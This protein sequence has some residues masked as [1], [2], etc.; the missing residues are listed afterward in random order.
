LLQWG[1]R[2]DHNF[3]TAHFANTSHT[4][5]NFASNMPTAVPESNR[6]SNATITMSREDLM[7]LSV[8][9][10]K[11]M[12]KERDLP[13]GHAGPQNPKWAGKRHFNRPAKKLFCNPTIHPTITRI[14]GRC[15]LHG[16]TPPPN[17]SV[18]G[19]PFHGRSGGRRVLSWFREKAIKSHSPYIAAAYPS[20]PP[21]RSIK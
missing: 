11:D 18:P 20:T 4:T 13:A 7:A 19:R 10:L 1:L 12:L 3:A 16:R 6:G 17:D 8:Q 14:S 5:H 9:E 2:C 21:Q 15:R